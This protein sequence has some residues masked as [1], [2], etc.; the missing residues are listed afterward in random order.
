MRHPLPLSSIK[1]VSELLMW[2]PWPLRW[3]WVCIKSQQLSISFLL[4]KTAH[5]GG[6]W[7]TN[8]TAKNDVSLLE[9]CSLRSVTLATHAWI[10]FSNHFSLKI[11]SFQNPMWGGQSGSLLPTWNGFKD[12][13]QSE[14]KPYPLLLLLWFFVCSLAFNTLVLAA[15][16]QNLGRKHSPHP[17]AFYASPMLRHYHHQAR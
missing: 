6:H 4:Y 11:F 12:Q 15:L 2:G 14:H 1:M 7:I 10:L 3:D 16:T 9:Y 5:N 8:F 17:A 13:L